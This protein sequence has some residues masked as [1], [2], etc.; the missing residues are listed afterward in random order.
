MPGTFMLTAHVPLADAEHEDD[1]RDEVAETL[2]WIARRLDTTYAEP[3]SADTARAFD[4][5]HALL[6]ALR[7]GV[8][9]PPLPSAHLSV[10]VRGARFEGRVIAALA[11]FADHQGVGGPESVARLPGRVRSAW[12]EVTL[13]DDGDDDP[14]LPVERQPPREG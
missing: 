11:A 10:Q 2:E 1:A 5:A 9:H 3:L 8:Q 4:A 6:D 13:A 7:L 14:P 12:L